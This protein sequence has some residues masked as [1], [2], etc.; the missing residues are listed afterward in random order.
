MPQAIDTLITGLRRFQ[1]LPERSEESLRQLPIRVVEF[2]HNQDIVH[3]GDRP[4]ESCLL[5]EGYAARAQYLRDG[6][7]QLDAIHVPGDF[8]DLHSLHLQQMD[9]GVVAMG[10]CKTGFVPHRDLLETMRGDQDLMWTL[11]QTAVMDAAICRTWI[12]CLGR[13]P[14]EKHLAHLICELFVRLREINLLEGN[15]FSFP[16]M[17]TDLADMLGLSTVHVSRTL[18]LL[19]QRGL[20]NVDRSIFQVLDFDGLAQFAEFDE[21]YLLRGK[22]PAVPLG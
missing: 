22:A 4:H 14:A 11:W 15:A 3:A 10:P 5:I 12:T 16:V 2:S 17:Q 8:V 13:R 19:H 1:K 9:H 7:R 6:G 20:V 18:K 21:T